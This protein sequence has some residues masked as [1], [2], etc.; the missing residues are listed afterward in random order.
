MPGQ[1][2]YPDFRFPFHG[3]PCGKRA[4]LPCQKTFSGGRSVSPGVLLC[5]KAGEKAIPFLTRE[6]PAMPRSVWNTSGA[7]S[8]RKSGQAAVWMDPA[9]VG[10]GVPARVVG[11]GP[12]RAS[13]PEEGPLLLAHGAVRSAPAAWA[14]VQPRR[15]DRLRGPV[16]GHSPV[17]RFPYGK[18]PS[19]GGE[20]LSSFFLRD[21]CLAGRWPDAPPGPGAGKIRREKRRSRGCRASLRTVRAGCGAIAPAGG[22]VDSGPFRE[23]YAPM[24]KNCLTSWRPMANAIR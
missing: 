10:G 9:P 3:S 16:H 15:A 20:R 5:R 19:R 14:A 21:A 4:S 1:P 8:R 13:I 2:R 24:F 17:G 12:Y 7:S 6:A 11:C 23:G 18:P 22:A